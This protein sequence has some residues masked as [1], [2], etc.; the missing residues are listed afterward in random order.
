MSELYSI[1]ALLDC[2]ATGSFIDRDFVHSKRINTRTLSWN[3]SV[4]NVNGSSNE[5]EQ[6]TEVIDIVLR[7]KTHCK[8]MLLAVSRLRKQSLILGYDWLKDHNPK[9]DWEKR[10]VEI[11]RCLLR[12]EGRHALQKEQTRQ[13]RME[14]RALQ[15]CHDGPAP[16]LQEESESEEEPLQTHHP[17]WELGDQLFLTHLLP[18]PDQVELQAMATTSQ[19]LVEGARRSVEA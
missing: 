9:I 15:S 19:R 13:K 5:A 6:I 14:L 12:C 8:R 1:K 10:E 18:E 16:L 17:S 4:F 3:I 2:R 11:T 7:Y